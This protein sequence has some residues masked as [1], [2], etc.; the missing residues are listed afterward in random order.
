MKSFQGFV[1]MLVLERSFCFIPDSC[2]YFIKHV[3]LSL[4]LFIKRRDGHK[5][6][7]K[8]KKLGGSARWPANLHCIIC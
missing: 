3:T 1:L 6:G 5:N 7:P 4:F 2:S 8:A